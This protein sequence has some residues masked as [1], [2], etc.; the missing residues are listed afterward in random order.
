M[1]H[2]QTRVV[3]NSPLNYVSGEKLQDSLKNLPTEMARLI[4]SYEDRRDT[5]QKGIVCNMKMQSNYFWKLD[6]TA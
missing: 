6:L 3:Y 1:I 2:L 4:K 5:L